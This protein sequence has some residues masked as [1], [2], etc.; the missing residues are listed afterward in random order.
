MYSFHRAQ[1]L[2]PVLVRGGVRK[3]S[4]S[5][6][7]GR[8]AMPHT[9][10]SEHMLPRSHMR[11]LVTPEGISPV[12]LV[13]ASSPLLHYS[14]RF[15]GHGS[16]RRF[17]WPG[18]VILFRSSTTSASILLNETRTNRYAVLLSG[19]DNLTRHRRH[20]TARHPD[21]ARLES[22]FPSAIAARPVTGIRNA[23][24][25]ATARSSPALAVRLH[26]ATTARTNSSPVCPPSREA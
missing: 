13:P 9:V 19:P 1:I 10:T 21:G 15:V 14:G 11:A 23:G 12:I 25:A 20:C 16:A 17:D 22:V 6:G 3:N 18:F 5:S 7:K 4:F 24:T 2:F 8:P 26:G